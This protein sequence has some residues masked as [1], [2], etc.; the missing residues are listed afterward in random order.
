[1]QVASGLFFLEISGWLA[2]RVKSHLTVIIGPHIDLV[3]NR[4]LSWE[5]KQSVRWF[6]QMSSTMA[7]KQ[8]NILHLSRYTFAQFMRWEHSVRWKINLLGSN[9]LTSKSQRTWDQSVLL[10]QVDLDCDPQLGWKGTRGRRWTCP[11]LPQRPAGKK[12]GVAL[13]QWEIEK[14]DTLQAL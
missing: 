6:E 3:M 13:Q 5:R 8:E 11:S 2:W 1:M 14:S 7:Q 12:G 4:T 9:D 10:S